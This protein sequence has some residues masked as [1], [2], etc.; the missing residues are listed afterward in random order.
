MKWTRTLLFLTLLFLTGLNSMAREDYINW[1]FNASGEVNSTPLLA[2]SV[3][4]VGSSDS[5]L[6]AL[7]TQTGE[8]IW[9]Y[10]T[11]N[12]IFSSPVRYQD[13]ICIESGNILYGID[14]AG[15]YQ[16]EV[17][18]YE[19]EITNQLD[20][21]NYFHSS[22]V[23]LDSIAYIAS[24]KGNVYGINVKD[25]SVVWH[26]QTANQETIRVTPALFD[27]TLYFG[28]WAGVFYAYDLATGDMAWQYDTRDDATYGWNNG[29]QTRVGIFDSAVYFSGRN[30]RIYCLD[31]KTGAVNWK[32]VSPTN[33]WL[34]GGPVIYDSVLY[35]GS[36]DQHLAYAFNAL[37][38][39]KI[40]ETM[41][42]F[43]IW[44]R[45][46][47]DDNYAYFG[48][49]DFYALDKGTGEIKVRFGSEGYILSS[50][51][52]A[53]SVIYFG[54]TN[55][56]VI[57]IDQKKF[58]ETKYSASA[59]TEI[60]V[61]LGEISV[62]EGELNTSAYIYNAGEYP[63]TVSVDV[64]TEGDNLDEA[65]AYDA[66]NNTPLPAGDSLRID[67]RVDL[68]ILQNRNYQIKLSCTYTH[69]L[70]TPRQTG[71]VKFS[72]V[73][74]ISGLYQL[75]DGQAETSITN[76]Y[77]NPASDQAF[78]EYAISEKEHVQ[79]MVYDVRGKIVGTLVDEIQLSGTYQVNLQ[80]HSLPAGEYCIIVF[81][82]DKIFSRKL[83]CY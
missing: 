18:L 67:F 68:S 51:V 26:I 22:A 15:N 40:F 43:R 48:S 46:W 79:V 13:I 27:S 65:L 3:L 17:E 12:Q 49:G 59:L 39:E 9:H 74:A 16:W 42:D 1:I 57:A 10:R 33:Q 76:I 25:G 55:N 64:S 60:T 61:D 53:D 29:I 80:T 31:A 36:S 69:N 19:G 30:C 82:G 81:A 78:I 7:S 52:I 6:Y 45:A 37:T 50:P 23:L 5:N 32:W 38:G 24:E 71:Y 4:Y 56:E 34:V 75:N 14:T 77:P 20:A 44:S 83:L 41:V 54:T 66:V 73:D 35:Q 47:A 62:T 28:D 63:D 58:L 70:A 2:D 8:E 21:W 72:V 11:T